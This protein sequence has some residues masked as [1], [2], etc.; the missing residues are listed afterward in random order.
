VAVVRVNRA[1]ILRL[2]SCYIVA[3]TARSLP[4]SGSTAG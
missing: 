4:G 2:A 3:S 1:G